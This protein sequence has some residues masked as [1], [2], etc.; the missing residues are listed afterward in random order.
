MVSPNHGDSSVAVVCVCVCVCP[1]LCV[2]PSAC[3]IDRQH[4]AAAAAGG[5]AAEVGRG[6]AADIDR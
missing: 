5:F 1:G 3:S 4:S 2:A 6:P